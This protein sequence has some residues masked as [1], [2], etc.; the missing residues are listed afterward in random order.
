MFASEGAADIAQ[1]SVQ[2]R[3]PPHRECFWRSTSAA[4]HLAISGL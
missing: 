4:A 2:W 1:V 3:G